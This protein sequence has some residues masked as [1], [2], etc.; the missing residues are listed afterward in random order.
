[1]VK[2][3]LAPL[4]CESIHIALDMVRTLQL[5][6]RTTVDIL[7]CDTALGA[8]SG[9]DLVRRIRTTPDTAYRTVPI[10]L[11]STDTTPSDIHEALSAGISEFVPKPF[12]AR[13]LLSAIF[14]VAEQPRGFILSRNYVGPDRRGVVSGVQSVDRTTFSERLPARIV[15]PVYLKYRQQFDEP[16]MVLP[17]YS[18]SRKV[19]LAHRLGASEYEEPVFVLAEQ[20]LEVARARFIDDMQHCI[21]SLLHLNRM[22]I[23]YPLARKQLV[24]S[25][26]ELAGTIEQ[27]ARG[28]GFVKS[29]EIARLL[30]MSCEQHTLEQN[31]QS[32]LIL[33]KHALTLSAILSSIRRQGD[34]SVA[35]DLIRDLHD[36]IRQIG[37]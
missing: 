28:L 8:T 7:V 34:E 20:A 32:I 35:T 2:K 21:S 10:I 3:V 25:L 27:H 1:M 36:Q 24:R 12:S 31:P 29:T 17:D 15:P 22:M 18:L 23:R 30:M 13:M 4:G 33:E 19:G 5:L 16:C 9:L 11:L 26:C 14:A 6:R 37:G